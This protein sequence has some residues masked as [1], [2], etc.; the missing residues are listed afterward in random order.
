MSGEMREMGR[1]SGYLEGNASAPSDSTTRLAEALLGSTMS[2]R[3]QSL[4][5]QFDELRDSNTVHRVL[6]DLRD[7]YQAP[8]K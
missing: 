4:L 2:K 6:V 7:S 8:R 5:I 3:K 1:Q